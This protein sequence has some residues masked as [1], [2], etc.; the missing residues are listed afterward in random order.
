MAKPADSPANRR[1][2]G[3]RTLKPKLVPDAADDVSQKAAENKKPP[4]GMGNTEPRNDYNEKTRHY[5]GQRR[6][7]SGQE[8]DS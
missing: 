1:E 4:S 6:P 7:R 5:D 8:R 3:G 2:T